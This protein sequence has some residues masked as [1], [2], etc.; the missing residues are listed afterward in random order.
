LLGEPKPFAALADD[1]RSGKIKFSAGEDGDQDLRGIV[2]GLVSAGTPQAERALEALCDGRHPQHAAVAHKVLTERTHG[3]DDGPWFAHPFCLRILR[4]ALD[5][6]TPTGATYL[7]EK[8]RFVRKE[9]NG[10]SSGNIPDFLSDPAQR[11]NKAGERAA[12]AAA[13]KVAEIV[14]G[15]PRYHPLF[16]DADRRLEAMKTALDRFK[17]SY[18]R[19]VGRERDILNISPWNPAF[20]PDIRPLGHAASADDVKTGKAI[21]HLAGKGKPADLKLP[22]RAVLKRDEDKKPPS[23]LLIVQAEVDAEGSLIYGVITCEGIRS[24]PA[25]DVASVKTFADLDREEK[26]AAE[27]KKPKKE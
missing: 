14:V 16:N 1:F 10:M 2:A 25:R 15:L 13:L 8:D 18:R 9:E 11:R 26:A 17:G 12:D 5:D 27:S 22:A 3:F 20:L 7:I 24:I 21:F 4:G 23:L 6:K 19:A